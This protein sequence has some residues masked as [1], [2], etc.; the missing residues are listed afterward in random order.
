M[1]VT[2]GVMWNLTVENMVERCP[3]WNKNRLVF[4]FFL[5]GT[6]YNY[7]A[8]LWQW[9]KIASASGNILYG[10]LTF[11]LKSSDLLRSD[12]AIFRLRN[13]LPTVLKTW[14]AFLPVHLAIYYLQPKYV[15][16]KNQ[17]AY[18]CVRLGTVTKIAVFFFSSIVTLM[19]KWN[20]K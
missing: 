14:R 9:N 8:I 3:P 10:N 13:R 7:R 20:V 6:V 17:S 2:G 15:Y 18:V 1:T 4:A 12:D 11:S 19:V 5:W 16:I